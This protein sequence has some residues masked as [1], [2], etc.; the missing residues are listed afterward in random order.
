MFFQ[1]PI[2]AIP[3]PLYYLS[4]SLPTTWAAE[5]GRSIMSRGWGLEHRQVWLGLVV[6]F[7]WSFVFFIWAARSLRAKK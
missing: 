1:W 3:I 7:A 2:E 4:L 5:A 6:P